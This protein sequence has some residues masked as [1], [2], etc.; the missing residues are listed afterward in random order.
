M[1]SGSFSITQKEHVD[2][3]AFFQ[4]VAE[5]P[6]ERFDEIA[7]IAVKVN[8][9]QVNKPTTSLLVKVAMPRTV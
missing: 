8:T 4:L 6:A 2:N 5:I 3:G 1:F 7:A 9:K